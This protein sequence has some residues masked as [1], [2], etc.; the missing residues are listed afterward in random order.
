MFVTANLRELLGQCQRVSDRLMITVGHERMGYCEACG[1]KI[2]THCGVVAPGGRYLWVGTE[3]VHTLCDDRPV[4][5]VEPGTVWAD[6]GREYILPAEDWVALLRTHARAIVP[7]GQPRPDHFESFC[8]YRSD[9]FTVYTLNRF[10]ASILDS[11]ARFGQLT[12]KQY[13]AADRLLQ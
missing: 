8:V 12:V 7:L 13:N 3:C 2:K 1:H 11:L 4:L 6:G 10:L 9:G 5:D